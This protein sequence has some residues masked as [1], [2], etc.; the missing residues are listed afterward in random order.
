MSMMFKRVFCDKILQL[1]D[2][3]RFNCINKFSH[4]IPNDRDT[5]LSKGTVITEKKNDDPNNTSNEEE[6]K[7]LLKEA[8]TY[9][10]ANDKNWATTP[11]PANAPTSVEEEN[12][13]IPKV[14]PVER[15]IIL[16]P[17]QGTLK[18]GAIKKYLRFPGVKDIF[19]LANEILGYN[20][21]N[22]CLK[23][24]QDKLDLTKFNQP[25]TVVSSLAAL[26]QL[27]EERQNVFETCIGT[28]G[29]S[30]GELSAL[31]FS[32]AISFE[33]GIR[34]VAVRGNMMQMASDK[35]GQGMLSVYCPPQIKL[36]KVLEDAIAWARDLGVP[37]P[38]C[39]VSVFLYTQNKI[40]AGNEEALRYIE[41]NAKV[42][43]LQK[44]KRLPVS[45]AFHTPLMQPAIQ[46]FCEKLREIPLEEPRTKVYSN[47][48][49]RPYRNTKSIK[50]LLVKQIISP[51]KW[52]QCIQRIYKRPEGTPFP[53]TFDVGSG[54]RMKTILKL[55]NAKAAESCIVI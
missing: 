15:S 44:L 36:S 12:I 6:V 7:R 25:A 49:G 2:L 48:T 9:S 27:R 4:N 46:K 31:I 33:D 5:V 18:V 52:E 11:Y 30:V 47:Y 42:V 19:D 8:A 10:D 45:G 50:G 21:L 28:A 1:S 29:Y 39:K 20:L 51:V 34:L 14:N 38:I 3:Y 35:I 54:G 37:N 24:P 17:G 32:G 13:N 23:G 55:I 26:E 43:G 41:K 53:R 40:I 22:I 16:F